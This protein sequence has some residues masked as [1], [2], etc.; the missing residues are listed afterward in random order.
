[1]YFFLQFFLLISAPLEEAAPTHR[2]L[3]ADISMS[4]VACARAFDRTLRGLTTSASGM[5]GK[6]NDTRLP[7]TVA[8]IFRRASRLPVP[9]GAFTFI[10]RRPDALDRTFTRVTFA[11]RRRTGRRDSIRAHQ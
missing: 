3:T 8:D 2:L 11:L 9:P 6:C 1:M 10:F 4:Y 5:F 7:G